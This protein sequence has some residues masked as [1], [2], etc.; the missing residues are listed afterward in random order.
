MEMFHELLFSLSWLSC[1]VHVLS[2]PGIHGWID[3][4][5]ESTRI[6]QKS[7]DVHAAESET[8]QKKRFDVSPEF[9]MPCTE[10]GHFEE[11][12]HGKTGN[13]VMETMETGFFP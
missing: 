11:E 10:L 3:S 13:W 12:K 8:A 4:V 5:P 1:K 2:T 9:R 6:S 7:S